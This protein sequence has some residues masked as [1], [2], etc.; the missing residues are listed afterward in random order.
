MYNISI[1]LIFI[2]LLRYLN[3]YKI[4]KSPTLKGQEKNDS[5]KTKTHIGRVLHSAISTGIQIKRLDCLD[6][7][8]I[9]PENA[10]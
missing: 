8:S 2:N 9:C 6:S 5:H 1:M 7:H 4:L 10:E 3:I